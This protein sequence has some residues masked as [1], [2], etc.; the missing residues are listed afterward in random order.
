LDEPTRSNASSAI[1]DRLVELGWLDVEVVALYRPFDGEVDPEPI[2]ARARIDGSITCYPV[3]Q[4]STLGFVPWDGM[5]PL[6]AGEFGIE[7]PDAPA[8][9]L[10][11]IGL[12]IVPLVGFDR[13]CHRLGMGRGYYDATFGKRPAGTRLVGIAF[14]EQ[15][16][17]EIGVDPWDV[18]LDAV[19]TPTRTLVPDA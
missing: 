8:V 17:H 3:V 19:I 13:H 18:H 4:G 16:T 12:V 9:D 6:R 14:D 15:Q 5:A 10:S 1:V 7:V 11:T 2:A